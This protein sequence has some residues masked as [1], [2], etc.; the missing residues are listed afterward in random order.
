M[1]PIQAGAPLPL[2]AT[3]TKRGVNFAI[4]SSR[5]TR[6]EL[7]LFDSQGGECA[8]HD[9][10]AR[11]GDTWHGFLPARRA[12]PFTSYGYR[13]HG[14][15]DPGQGERFDPAIVLL[16]PYAR[17]VCATDPPRAQVIRDDFDWSGDRP[18]AVPWRD[19]VI[20]EL[21]VKG[22]TQRHPEVPAAWRG[23]YLGLTVAPVIEHL[24]SLG[25]TTVE[26][27][28]CQEFMTEGF[29]TE[30]GLTNYWGYN[31]AAWFAPTS[32]YAVEDAT[33]EF[34]YMVKALHGAGIEVI[35][36]VVFNHTAEGNEQGP[37]FS[38]KGI[39]NPTY[40]RLVAAD[41]RQYENQT[42]TGNTVNCRHPQVRQLIVDC[43]RHWTEEMHVDG[44]RFDLA[45]VLARNAGGFDENSPFFKAVRADPA[46]AYVKLIAEP[47]D[48]GWGGYQL[49]R[50]PSGW[51]EWND[52]YR[53]A[54]SSFWRRDAGRVGELAERLAGSSDLFRHDGRRPTASV[55]FIT[56]HDGFTLGDLV[57]YDARH[58]EA[59]LENNADG[60]G[61]NLSWN[62]G[63]EGPTEDPEVNALRRRQRKNLLATLFLSLGTPMLL[64]GDEFARTQGGNNNAYCQDNP[65]TW[66]DWELAETHGDLLR[67][68]RHLAQ[69]RLRHAE[70]RRETFLKGTVSRAGIKDIAWLHP[71]GDE[72]TQVDWADG[73]LRTL[74]A[75]FGKR[76]NSPDRLLL[77]LNADAA[78]QSFV[79]PVTP[80]GRYWTRLFDTSIDDL[81]AARLDD[82]SQYSLTAS[83][84]ALLEC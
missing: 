14:P 20:Y 74:G 59:N 81:Q 21:H 27:L 32:R 23:K 69:L 45:T 72:M 4:F 52:K 84:A 51:S 9:L 63:T 44:F 5:A 31:P 68:V 62:C 58:N 48:I 10:P 6:I 1:K 80:G 73:N 28:P 36:D 12:T 8:R 39:D 38:W 30:R 19:T 67:F 41:R 50:F 83:S 53:D 26:L 35:L 49:G 18:P 70:F 65:I 34:K 42:G 77:L 60:H 16:D 54:I 22:F 7:C 2:G 56:A 25:V 24:R 13:V 78:P 47:W 15:E 17:A 43:L 3:R 82:T 40:Y 75:W 33:S 64:A 57:S 29:L 76:N 37:L 11:S 55:N 71:R 61:N 79:L 66:V 46:L